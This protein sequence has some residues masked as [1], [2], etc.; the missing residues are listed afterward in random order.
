[1]MQDVEVVEEKAKSGAMIAPELLST[2]KASLVVDQQSNVWLLHD[3]PFTGVLKWME[4]DVPKASMVLVMADGT[5][6]DIGLTINKKMGECLEN[7]QKAYT[8]LTDGEKI[9][10]MYMVPIIVGKI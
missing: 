4:Y 6:Q 8:F 1:M 5:T 10:D 2:M 3:K 7:A 9:R